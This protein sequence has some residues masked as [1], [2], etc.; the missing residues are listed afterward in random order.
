MTARPDK[1]PAPL[2]PGGPEEIRALRFRIGEIQARAEKAT[3]GP[4]EKWWGQTIRLPSQAFICISFPHHFWA[5][6][7]KRLLPKVSWTE[8][9]AI[10]EFIAA[11]R[12]DIP[13]LCEQLLKALDK[14]KA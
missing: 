6:R 13:W 8:K 14:E 10:V 9:Q 4:W 5:G 3:P 1:S 11:A 2:G 7:E 12:S